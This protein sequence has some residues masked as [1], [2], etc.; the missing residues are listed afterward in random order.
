[1]ASPEAPLARRIGWAGI[2]RVRIAIRLIGLAGLLIGCLAGHYIT[3]AVV[4]PGVW[5]RRFLRAAARIAGAD[6][7]TAG[8]AGPAPLMLIANHVSW[9]DIMALAGTTGTAFVAH[10]GLSRQPF[11]RRLCELNRTVFIAR[12]HRGAV[13]GQADQLRA[14][15]SQGSVL[16][17]FLEGTTGDGIVLQRFKSSLLAAI[18]PMPSGLRVQPVLIDYGLAAREIAWTGGEPGL[19]N[20]LR[21]LARSR[22]LRV[23]LRF[24]PPLEGAEL[25]SR[26]TMAAA[27]EQ[28][29]RA[30]LYDRW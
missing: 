8:H 10:D 5:P 28:R 24:L 1:M 3:R 15:L 19:H 12:E 26:K 13:A 25:T 30:A 14:A 6:I 21:I 16:T 17:L 7:R 23:T 20:F 2:V 22:R 9:L 27:A 29:I 4:G 18:D 11:L